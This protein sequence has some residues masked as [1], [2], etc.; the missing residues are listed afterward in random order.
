M[1]TTSTFSITTKRLPT[2]LLNALNMQGIVSSFLSEYGDKII[3]SLNSHLSFQ[4]DNDNLT[5]IVKTFHLVFL[6]RKVS[7]KSKNRLI[8]SMLCICSKFDQYLFDDTLSLERLRIS[9]ETFRRNGTP[10][11]P[12]DDRRTVRNS[13]KIRLQSMMHNVY[14]LHLL[15]IMMQI[16]KNQFILQIEG[17]LNS[18]ELKMGPGPLIVWF[19][20][21][22][23]R[24]FK[25][26]F[27]LVDD[28]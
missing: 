27:A 28:S 2:D 26:Y 19:V 7:Q 21:N 18:H 11:L 9:E 1:S 25:E 12:S 6:N 4:E 13:I 3:S 14:M 23:R 10:F 22:Q 20:K 8:G 15:S 5:I 16:V 17:D 24:S